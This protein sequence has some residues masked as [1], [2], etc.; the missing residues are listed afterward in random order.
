MTNQKPGDVPSKD[1]SKPAVGQDG[2]PDVSK[3]RGIPPL[4]EPDVEGV[5]N[6]SGPAA[7]KT[8]PRSDDVSRD[9]GDTKKD[10][11]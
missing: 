7:E 9:Q 2:E 11:T 10:A 5:G 3:T 4:P 1:Q 8:H 6:E